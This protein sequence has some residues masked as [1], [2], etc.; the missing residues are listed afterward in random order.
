MGVVEGRRMISLLLYDRIAQSTAFEMDLSPFI[1]HSWQRSIRA[2]GGY[3][4]GDFTLSSES[5][6]TRSVINFFR[7]NI[8]KRVVEKTAG[9]VS[10]EGEI[11]EMDLTLDGAVYQVSMNYERWHNRIK[12]SYTDSATSAATATAWSEN[13]NSSGSYGQSEYIDVVGDNYDSTS[14]TAL[15]DRR[16]TEYAFP[17]AQP[18]G[19]LASGGS[20]GRGD[21]A[22][23]VM[24]AGYVFSMNRRFRESDTAAANASAQISTLV[25]ESEFVTAGSIAPNTLQV[26]ISGSEIPFR[27]W[28]GIEE[29]VLMGDGS[30]NRWSGGVYSRRFH[31]QQAATLVSHYW[32]DGQLLDRGR[33]NVVPSLIKPDIIVQIG[34]APLGPTPPGGNVWDNPRNVYIEEVEFVA[35]DRYRL[36]PHTGV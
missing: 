33:T 36:I 4:T 8:G 32:A 19:G 1:R 11:V 22:L 30:G 2:V 5:M 18:T 20:A 16:L 13:T 23:R 14:A 7:Y 35:P 24:V 12:V 27:L 21:V 31:Y 17:R 6:A 26:P 3:W 10:W 29:I 9:I 25:G 15:R 34:G 28:D